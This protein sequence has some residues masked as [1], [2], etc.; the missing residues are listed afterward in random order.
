GGAQVAHLK[1][2][3]HGSLAYTGIG[4]GTGRAVVLGL[5]GEMP[6]TVDPDRMEAVIAQVEATGRVT[7]PGHPT[8]IFQPKT[9]L[10]YDKKQP[11]P[12]HANG[13]IFSA[14]DADGRMLLKRIYYSIG[15]GFVVTDTELEAMRLSK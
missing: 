12:G 11:L 4:H 3:L 2:S 6:H 14:H 10:V 8:Y 7:P 9:D 13:M 15:G 1:V 5:T